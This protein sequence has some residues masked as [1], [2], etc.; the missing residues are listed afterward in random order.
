MEGGTRENRMEA[1]GLKDLIFIFECML[2]MFRWSV[3]EAS[4][5]LL[6]IFWPWLWVAANLN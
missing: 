5:G 1:K 3:T 4:G 6:T 2:A